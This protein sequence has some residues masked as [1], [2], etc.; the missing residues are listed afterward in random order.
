MMHSRMPHRT[1]LKVTSASRASVGTSGSYASP[2][3]SVCYAFE[4]SDDCASASTVGMLTSPGSF[5]VGRLYRRARADALTACPP[6]CDVRFASHYCREKLRYGISSPGG[7]LVHQVLQNA[8]DA[9]Q[10]L[11]PE[12]HGNSDAANN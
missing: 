6:S 5:A 9:S 10:A 4:G 8:V 11:R 12:Q 7:N 3:T 2:E 1:D